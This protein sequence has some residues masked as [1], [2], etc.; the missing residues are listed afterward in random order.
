MFPG[1]YG[2][3]SYCAPCH[4]KQTAGGIEADAAGTNKPRRVLRCELQSV[5][6][7]ASW[8]EAHWHQEAWRIPPGG[9]VVMLTSERAEIVRP[10]CAEV[11]GAQRGYNYATRQG[12]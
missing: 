2:L 12:S 4:S 3:A 8:N 7:Q 6:S 5:C 1:H 9:T 11:L 10:L